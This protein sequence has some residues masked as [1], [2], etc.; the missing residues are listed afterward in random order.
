MDEPVEVTQEEF[1]EFKRWCGHYKVVFGLMEWDF[2]YEM[3]DSDAHIS[4][5]RFDTFGYIATIALSKKGDALIKAKPE[6][7]RDSALH[8]VLHI[9]LSHIGI[10][11]RERF[12]TKY[13]ID[14]EEER[15]TNLFQNIIRKMEV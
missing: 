8:E 12:T 9:I 3:D 2:Y 13:E 10:M 6:W 14:V 15:L 5:C 4:E 7:M 1:E 11:A